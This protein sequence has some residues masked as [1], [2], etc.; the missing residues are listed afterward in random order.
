MRAARGSIQIGSFRGIPVRVHFSLLLVL[1]LLAFLFGG[2]FRRAAE[3]AE[4]PPER[5]GGSPALWGLVV[6]VGLFAS[7]FV[8]ELAHTVYALRRGGKVRSITL[9]MVGGVSELTEAPPRPRDEALMAAV[10][11][12]TSILLAALLGGAT[13]LLQETRSFNVQFAFFYMASLNLFLG[14]FNLLPAFPM[15]GGRIVRASLAGRLGMVRATQVASWLGRGFAVLFGVGA[16]LSFNPFLAVIAF[17]IFMGAQGEA[18]QVRMKATLER[19]P[20]A[21]LMTPRR[22]GVD[23]GASLEQTLWDL[24]R[25]RLLLLPVTEDGRPVGQVSLETVRAVP[26]S[27]RMTRSAREVM[28]PAVVARLDEDGWTALRRM[29][30]EEMPQLVVVEAD[31]ALAGTLD[32]NDVQRGLS[33]YQAREERSGQQERRW[34]QERPA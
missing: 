29:A 12:L 16:V 4:V 33:L 11:P 13:W 32:V 5:L 21:D 15:D 3:V 7:V 2:A 25:E 31:G 9:M 1:P 28:V 23:A 18:Q 14:V 27:E 34:R 20:V 17:F 30:E 19:V 22:V 6:A 26:D 24:R 8:H 10:G